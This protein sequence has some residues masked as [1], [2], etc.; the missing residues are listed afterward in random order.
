MLRSR[1]SDKLNG[2]WANPHRTASSHS[3]SR[4]C[5]LFGVKYVS[6]DVHARPRLGNANRHTLKTGIRV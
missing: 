6:L 5:S 1:L 2:E 3:L 4:D